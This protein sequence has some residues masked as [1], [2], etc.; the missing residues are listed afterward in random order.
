M[1][2]LVVTGGIA[3]G[4]SSFLRCV[5]T[6]RPDVIVFDCDAAVHQLLTEREVLAKIRLLFGNAVFV[7]DALDRAALRQRVF[8]DK[9]QRE[10][11]ESLLHP[12]VRER[13]EQSFANAVS[14]QP[15]GLFIADVPLYYETHATYPNEMVV[16]V[17]TTRTT[18]RD[19]LM[20]RSQFSAQEAEAIMD[21]QLPIDEKGRRADV[22]IWNEGP[23]DRLE[24]QARI[25]LNPFSD[26]READRHTP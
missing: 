12:L 2:R 23:L 24:E 5:K 16:V 8:A 20:R 10:T 25:F 17:A 19:R 11:L 13:G 21:A 3:T 26:S 22:L 14:E 9:S 6:L 4:K 7:G 18:Q 1:N 15:Q